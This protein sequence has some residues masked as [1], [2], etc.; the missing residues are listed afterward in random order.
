MVVLALTLLV[1]AVAVFSLGS[2]LWVILRHLW[3]EHIP[4]GIT[5]PMRLRILSCFL[6]LSLTWVSLCFAC[7]FCL[8]LGQTGSWMFI[9]HTIQ[10]MLVF[11]AFPLL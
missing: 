1:G 4:E 7:F 8:G 5:H 3:T 2:L 9:L 10:R 11:S 6:H